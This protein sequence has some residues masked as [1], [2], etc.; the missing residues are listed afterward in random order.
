[1]KLGVKLQQAVLFVGELR[2]SDSLGFASE[3]VRKTG[4]VFNFEPQVLSLPP[5]APPELPRIILK[6]REQ[7]YGVQFAQNRIN[8]FYQDVHNQ[9]KDLDTLFP[10]YRLHL[11]NVIEA[12]FEL[13][14]VHVP[15]LGCVVQLFRQMP[16][17]AN[18]FFTQ[19]FFREGTLSD[20]FQMQLA[21]LHKI[22]LEN[23]SVNRW[24]KYRTLRNQKEPFD[25]YAV[26]VDVDINT[27]EEEQHDFDA[28]EILSF[29]MLA[30][31]HVL[32]DLKQ[33]PLFD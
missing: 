32:H 9:N 33:F 6:N 30:K 5:Q 21:F 4:N 1:L 15:R 31:E 11:G 23:I 27:L 17:S 25:D 13:L 22:Q 2:V 8:F 12:V 28:A 29:F 16:E 20:P 26:A 19:H 18:R 24:V 3:F 10:T 14:P 7:S